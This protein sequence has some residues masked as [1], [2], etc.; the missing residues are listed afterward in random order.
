MPGTPFRLMKSGQISRAYLLGEVSQGLGVIAGQ[1]RNTLL[2]LR[3]LCSQLLDEV[4]Q[5]S[6]GWPYV[7]WYELLEKRSKMIS[8]AQLDDTAVGV[9]S[10][11]QLSPA[12]GSLLEVKQVSR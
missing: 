12:R 11:W 8:A 4:L 3:S 9:G 7:N 2:S 5:T 1:C 6:G 10:D